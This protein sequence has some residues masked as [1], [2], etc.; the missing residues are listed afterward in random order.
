MLAYC[1]EHLWAFA[2]IAVL[3]IPFVVFGI[4]KNIIGVWGSKNKK[5]DLISD[6][7]VF[8][9]GLVTLTGIGGVL[10]GIFETFLIWLKAH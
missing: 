8:G 4:G 3:G 2:L 9:G 5:D 7:C 1:L 10:L 6:I